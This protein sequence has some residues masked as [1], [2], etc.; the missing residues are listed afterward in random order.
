MESKSNSLIVVQDRLPLLAPEA[1]CDLMSKAKIVKK[2]IAALEEHA[3]ERLIADPD[4]LPGWQLRNT[5]D[6]TKLVMPTKYF[7]ALQE[8][9]PGLS[10]S[11]YDA[12]RSMVFGELKK[13]ISELMGISESKAEELMKRVAEPFVTKTPKAKSIVEIKSKK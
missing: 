12:C 4:S 10:A 5:G 13:L 9:V 3:R 6:T 1:V 2:F 7:T 11:A 8:C